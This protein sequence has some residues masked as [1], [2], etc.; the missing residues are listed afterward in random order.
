MIKLNKKL[1]MK[2]ADIKIIKILTCG[3]NIFYLFIEKVVKIFI[4]ML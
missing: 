3:F 1:S 2:W 4:N